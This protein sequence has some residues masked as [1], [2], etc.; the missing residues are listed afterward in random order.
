M[1][2][3][4]SSTRASASSSTHRRPWQEP[5]SR[6]VASLSHLPSHVW[7]M[8]VLWYLTQ[9]SVF[10]P[11]CPFRS[12]LPLSFSLFRCKP[13]AGGFYHEHRTPRPLLSQSRCSASPSLPCARRKDYQRAPKTF[14]LT[15]CTL[16]AYSSRRPNTRHVVLPSSRRFDSKD[17]RK[18][19]TTPLTIPFFPITPLPRFPPD[20][21]KL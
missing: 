1:S 11:R 4:M 16:P 9:A 5:S 7:S 18:E 20:D 2:C 8:N 21:V 3:F 13:I 14:T 6:W 19:P 15:P 12:P 10:S 17:K